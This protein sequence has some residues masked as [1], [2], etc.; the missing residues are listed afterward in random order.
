MSQMAWVEG[1]L[2]AAKRR[3]VKDSTIEAYALRLRDIT[4][5]QRLDLE[6]CPDSEVF[7]LLP[8]RR[9]GVGP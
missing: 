6:T 8:A 4:N 2:E 1:F 5:H 9:V 3:G 7:A